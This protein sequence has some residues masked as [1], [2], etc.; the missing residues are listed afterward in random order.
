MS[1]PVIR[2]RAFAW[3]TLR[4]SI[5]VLKFPPMQHTMQSI[6]LLTKLPSVRFALGRHDPTRPLRCHNKYKRH[7]RRARTAQDT[8][9]GCRCS[10]AW[11]QPC[12]AVY[13]QHETRRPCNNN[14]AAASPALLDSINYCNYFIIIIKHCMMNFRRI[15]PPEL[16]TAN[17][18][19]RFFQTEKEQEHLG[20]RA[21]IRWLGVFH[22]ACRTS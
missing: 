10:K 6:I 16:I 15:M 1:G 20:R 9:V 3:P 5:P 22:S 14:A 8:G 12:A 19:A 7:D 2:R 4:H 21:E 18:R 11:R 13:V 17:G